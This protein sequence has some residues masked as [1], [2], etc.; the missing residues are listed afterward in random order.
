MNQVEQWF[1]MLQRKRLRIADFADV[2]HLAPRLHTFVAQW[3]QHAHPFTWSSTSVTTV[4]AAC[5]Q[6]LQEAAR[7]A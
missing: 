3:N 7:A 6:P 2:A 1:S 5:E 4:M